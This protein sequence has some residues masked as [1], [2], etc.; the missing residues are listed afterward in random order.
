MLLQHEGLNEATVGELRMATSTLQEGDVARERAA[1][2]GARLLRGAEHKDCDAA[3]R[4]QKEVKKN[5]LKVQKEETATDAATTTV[6]ESGVM[7]CRHCSKGFV[8]QQW[9]RSHEEGCVEQLASRASNRKTAVL[10]P[11]ADLAQDQV[12]SA[13]SL[14]IGQG[15][16]FRGQENKEMF[17]PTTIKFFQTPRDVPVVKEGWAC[18][19][20]SGVKRGAFKKSQR[21]FLLT[22]FNNNGGP[23]IRERDAHMRMKTKFVDK[24]EDSDYC[25]HL[26]LSESQIKS[27]F[28]SETGRRK[29]AAVN[30]VIEKGFT[31]LSQSIQD[32]EEGGHDQNEGVVEAGGPPAP[33]P[34]RPPPAPP[35]PTKT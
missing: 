32:N 28:S 20:A 8:R 23:K 29:K 22:L 7:V 35:P 16:L 5:D 19:G 9:F 11:A 34:P 10:R 13:A 31:G 30:R 24:D 15:N 3:V 25:F 33:P 14:S 12:H 18:K 4:L 2:Q 6:A 27:W 26:V 21:D 1:G 17:F